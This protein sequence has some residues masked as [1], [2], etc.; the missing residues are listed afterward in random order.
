MDIQY[1][2][3][4]PN[5]PEVDIA[6]VARLSPNEENDYIR[7]YFSVLEALRYDVGPTCW[8]LTPEEWANGYNI[9]AFKITPGPIGTVRP[10]SRVGSAR[11]ELKF[12][13]PTA[14]NINVLLLSQ[15]GAEIQI[16][17]YKN[18]LLI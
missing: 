6:V 13:T 2:F 9:Y 15:Q 11:L 12:S 3:N 18:V 4:W 16:D 10:P 1:P 14:G 8:D 7:S 17:K 5:I